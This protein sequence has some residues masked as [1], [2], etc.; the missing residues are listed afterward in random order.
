MLHTH[1][2]VPPAS[3]SNTFPALFFPLTFPPLLPAYGSTSQLCS[4]MSLGCLLTHLWRKTYRAVIWSYRAKAGMERAWWNV[5]LTIIQ[6]GWKN[7]VRDEERKGFP[8]SLKPLPIRVII[9]SAGCFCWL[10]HQ[11]AAVNWALNDAWWDR[12]ECFD[13]HR[14]CVCVCVCFHLFT[15]LCMIMRLNLHAYVRMRLALFFCMCCYVLCLHL[16]VC[17]YMKD[18]P[19]NKPVREFPCAV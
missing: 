13:T 12:R 18:S 16:Y 8:Q 2:Q 3:S 9:K 4:V 6:R 17:V 10:E 14:V 1:K 5:P 15:W 7:G 11:D 19:F